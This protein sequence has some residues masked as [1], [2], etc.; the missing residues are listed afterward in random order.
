M[1]LPTAICNKAPAACKLPDGGLL[2][3]N[4]VLFK[5]YAHCCEP[6]PRSACVWRLRLS[7]E[8][9]LRAVG[10]EG[11]P[12]CCYWAPGRLGSGPAVDAAPQPA[13]SP[14]CCPAADSALTT[15]VAGRA[16]PHG[17]TGE[18][19]VA[20]A[21]VV[22]WLVT[23]QSSCGTGVVWEAALSSLRS[24]GPVLEGEATAASFT[25]NAALLSQTVGESHSHGL[26]TSQRSGQFPRPAL[27]VLCSLQSCLSQVTMFSGVRRPQGLFSRW[28]QQPEAK[29]KGTA[30]VN[31]GVSLS[32]SRPSL[33]ASSPGGQP[34]P[35]LTLATKIKSK[36][37]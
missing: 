1:G 5:I 29:F 36:K 23:V 17:G 13:V 34:A 6:P 30:T 9:R 26:W 20:E 2:I 31:L 10:T 32:R 22:P 18:M 3:G 21:H 35:G 37:K 4:H 8:Q 19:S 15:L 24:G 25:L 28:Q 16:A 27:H 14:A 7:R 12:R 33:P 11:A